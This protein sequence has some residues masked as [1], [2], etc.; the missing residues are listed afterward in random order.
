MMSR[1][2]SHRP[3]GCDLRDYAGWD[4]HL[5]QA[6]ELNERMKPLPGI[7]YFSVPCSATIRKPDGAYRPKRSIEPLFAAPPS[8]RGIF[9]NDG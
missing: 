1:G 5:D 4:M 8:D 3:D 2:T 7:Y 9:Q 6:R